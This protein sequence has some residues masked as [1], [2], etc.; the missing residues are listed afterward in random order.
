[1]PANEQK[2]GFE[3]QIFYGVAGNTA[4]SLIPET[5]DMSMTYSTDK[6]N[7]TARN[8]AGTIPI[9]TER[10]TTRKWQFDFNMLSVPGNEV[11]AAILAA[12][13]AGS[14][15]AFRSKDFAAGKGYDG[16]VIIEHK[17]GK[18]LRGE[19]T[20]DVT[21]KPTRSAGREPVLYT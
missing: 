21:V 19:Q 10:V 12:S 8:A 1:M 5:R 15:I 18:P 13:Y 16:D 7:T 9:E 6:G 2:M 11:Q 20:Y 4:G 3:G 17:L 14:P